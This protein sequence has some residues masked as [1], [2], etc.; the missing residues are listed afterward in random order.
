MT[1]TPTV[2]VSVLTPE[3]VAEIIA[4]DPTISAGI[5]IFHVQAAS[6]IASYYEDELIVLGSDLAT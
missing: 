6:G 4:I 3:G 1:N 2:G 5:D